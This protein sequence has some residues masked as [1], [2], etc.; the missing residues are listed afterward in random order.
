MLR[1]ISSLAFLV[2]LLSPATG[3]AD[4]RFR[5][6]G[7]L[8]FV[9]DTIAEVTKKCGPPDSKREGYQTIEQELVTGATR[10]VRVW[11]TEWRY[12]PYGKFPR[13]LM[14]RDGRLKRITR[15]QR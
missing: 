12:A 5:C 15:E 4:D 6:R 8:V 10:L 14:F 3:L 9:G 7:G 11:V 13:E 2:A 1:S